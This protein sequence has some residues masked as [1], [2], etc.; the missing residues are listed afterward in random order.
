[1]KWYKQSIEEGHF[2]TQLFQTSMKLP[3]LIIVIYRYT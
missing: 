1:M 3:T 2:S